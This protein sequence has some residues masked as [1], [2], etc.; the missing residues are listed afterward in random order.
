MR[1]WGVRFCDESEGGENRA[2]KKIG[3]KKKI[4]LGKKNRA[5]NK[6]AMRV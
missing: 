4:G 2:E 5:E 6:I 3:L 1:V